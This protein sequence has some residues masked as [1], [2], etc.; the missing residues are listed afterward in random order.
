MIPQGWL[1]DCKM[2][3]TYN[4]NLQSQGCP[5][6]ALPEREEKESLQHDENVPV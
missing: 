3:S 1:S 5:A 6:A 2:R 4:F